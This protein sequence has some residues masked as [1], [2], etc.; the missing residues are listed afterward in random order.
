MKTRVIIL[1]GGRSAEHEI[2][3]L[4]ARNVLA[5][6]DRRRFEPVLVGIDKQGRWR[7][8]SPATLAAATGDPRGL[9]LDD[10]AEVIDARVLEPGDVV[11]PMLHGTNGEEG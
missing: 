6:L 11:I 5:A 2:S 1:F 8:E 9:H 7:R 10:R 4:S 3:L